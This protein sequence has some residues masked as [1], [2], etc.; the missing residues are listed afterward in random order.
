MKTNI[1][2]WIAC[3]NDNSLYLYKGKPYK[4]DIYGHKCWYSPYD[5]FFEILETDLPEGINPQWEDAEPIEVEIIIKAKE[6]Q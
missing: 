3:D 6:N 4:T 1:K 5:D 2:A